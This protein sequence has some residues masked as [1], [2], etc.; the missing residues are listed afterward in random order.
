MEEGCHKVY[1]SCRW[2]AASRRHLESCFVRP[3]PL[4]CASASA[5]LESRPC[6]S[7]REESYDQD[8][9][10]SNDQIPVEVEYGTSL[11]G[12][13]GAGRLPP[14]ISFHIWKGKPLAA[15]LQTLVFIAPLSCEG[16]HGED[17]L[18]KH[19]RFCLSFCL[20]QC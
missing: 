2:W 17:Q 15:G 13:Q 16:Q 5:F 3:Q 9:L 20:C 18:T 1:L 19:S 8:N 7:C 12:E 11:C 10:G 6:T 14:S 4:S